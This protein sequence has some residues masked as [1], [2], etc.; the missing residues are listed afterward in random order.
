MAT[1][2]NGE[3]LKSVTVQVLNDNVPELEEYFTILLQNPQGGKAII[4]PDKV[5]VIVLVII[6]IN[7]KMFFK[8][9]QSTFEV[10]IYANDNQGG[11]FS[12]VT[13]SL[14]LDEDTQPEGVVL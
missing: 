13:T 11:V 9:I 12:I 2:A 6:I 1:F 4:N 14:S 7:F 8:N 10:G 3:T 5:W